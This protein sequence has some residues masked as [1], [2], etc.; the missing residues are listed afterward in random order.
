MAIKSKNR[1]F[2]ILLVKNYII[3]T[4][5]LAIVAAAIIYSMMLL[6]K[7]Y[8]GVPKTENILKQVSLLKSE[9]Y[10]K[11][12]TKELFGNN[13]FFEIVNSD[14]KIIYSSDKMRSQKTYTQGELESIHD[15]IFLPEWEAVFSFFYMIQ[16]KYWFCYLC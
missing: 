12:N 5:A 6:E 2:F 3:F 14:D 10:E 15:L 11:I 9:N 13:G 1:S 4:L 7:K 8:M 16:L